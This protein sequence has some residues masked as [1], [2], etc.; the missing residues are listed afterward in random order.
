[1]NGIGFI[2]ALPREIP[3]GFVRIDRKHELAASL[4]FAVYRYKPGPRQLTAAQVGIGQTRAAE[5][6]RQFIARFSPCALVSLGFAGGLN[7]RLTRGTLVI[8][9]GLVPPHASQVSTEAHKGLGDQFCAAAEAVRVPVQRGPVVTATEVVADATAKAAL[10]QACGADA[11]DM[12]TAGI[13]QAAREKNLPWVAMRAIVDG[14]ADSLPV[15]C[16]TMVGNDGHISM[17]ALMSGICRSPT[18]L[19]PML[20]LAAGAALAR[21]HLSRVI[22]YWATRLPAEG[23]L[24][25]G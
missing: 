9:T 14:A 11:V 20:T 16:L 4:P 18:L 25:R 2:V 21:R 17:R 22:T 6:T 3:T 8:A 1:L 12:E 7:P 24:I 19:G 5:G 23:P 15:E 13:A 10:R